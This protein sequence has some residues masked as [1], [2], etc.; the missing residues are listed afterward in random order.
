MKKKRDIKGLAQ[1]V[2]KNDN[3]KVRVSAAQILKDMGDKEAIEALTNVLLTTI[4]FGE[5]K[6]QIEAM[7]VI[8]GRVPTS[9]MKYT[10]LEDRTEA[11]KKAHGPLELHHVQDPLDEVIKEKKHSFI[12]QWFALLTLVEL[13]DRREEVLKNLISFSTLYTKATDSTLKTNSKL[14][15]YLIANQVNC[16][17]EETV[18]AL[19]SF[20][21]NAI[22][23]D[24]IIKIQDGELFH[25]SYVHPSYSHPYLYVRQE[26]SICALGAIGDPSERGR[27]EYIANRGSKSIRKAAKVALELYGKATYDEIKAKVESK[28]N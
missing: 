9:L 19:T 24:T 7:I 14:S 10:F 4:R 18:R 17:I 13:G 8:Q 11:L 6:D 5:E 22:A 25:G 28:R 21:G 26:D 12:S 3:P 27:L 16:L 2:S 23:R 1:L 20:R 15:M